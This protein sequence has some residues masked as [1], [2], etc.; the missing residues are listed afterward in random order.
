MNYS[1]SLNAVTLSVYEQQKQ[2]MINFCITI[3]YIGIKLQMYNSLTMFFSK[4]VS[5]TI[6]EQ[7][8]LKVKFSLLKSNQTLLII[9]APPTLFFSFRALFSSPSS[10]IRYFKRYTDILFKKIITFVSNE[11]MTRIENVLEQV[12]VILFH[13]YFAW[14]QLFKSLNV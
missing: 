8:M 7:H 11:K 10:S 3:W 9:L 6:T 12:D 14:K 2:K 4:T 5:I 13:N 1:S